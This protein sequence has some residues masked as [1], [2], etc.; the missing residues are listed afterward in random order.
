VKDGAWTLFKRQRRKSVTR[1][2][3]PDLHFSPFTAP[4]FFDPLIPQ[5]AIVYDLQFLT[6]PQFF[7][8]RTRADRHQHFLDACARSDRLT[9][10]SEFV[11]QS[12]LASS[13]RPPDSVQT[14][15]LT[16]LHAA[17]RDPDSESIAR[18][19]LARC[20]L[21]STRYLLYPANAWPHKN[22]RALVDAF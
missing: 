19:V 14:I 1:A 7:D 11:R 16:L 22:H 21:S 15:H 20:G 5:V 6:Y 12:V 13:E 2:A 4:F 18:K 3:L 9:C 10:I 8:D 17:D